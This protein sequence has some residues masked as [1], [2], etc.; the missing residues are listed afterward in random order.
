MLNI[1]VRINILCNPDDFYVKC[2][3]KSQHW[4][5]NVDSYQDLGE[6]QNK[7]GKQH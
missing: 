7:G 5:Q 2:D 6:K 4:H 1:P 3:N